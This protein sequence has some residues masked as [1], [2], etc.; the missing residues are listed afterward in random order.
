MSI[1]LLSFRSYDKFYIAS[2]TPKKFC[3]VSQMSI[4]I[5]QKQRFSYICFHFNEMRDTLVDY[6]NVGIKTVP[7]K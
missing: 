4:L 7:H 5:Y 6:K 1:Y 2:N 3:I